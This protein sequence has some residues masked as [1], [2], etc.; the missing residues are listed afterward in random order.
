MCIF[1]ISSVSVHGNKKRKLPEK[2]I[3][4][5]E[6]VVIKTVFVAFHVLNF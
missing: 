5:D 1:V 6:S 4:F 2:R 3:K